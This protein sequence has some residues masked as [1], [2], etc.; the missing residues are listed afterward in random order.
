[1]AQVFTGVEDIGLRVNFFSFPSED[2]YSGSYLRTLD[3]FL[4]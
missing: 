4:F 2:I 1:M 3:N